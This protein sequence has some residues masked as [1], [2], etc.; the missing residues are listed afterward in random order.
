MTE[1]VTTVEGLRVAL[2]RR[3]HGGSVGLVPTM[4]AL[5]AGHAA[6]IRRARAEMETVVVSV[7]VNPTQ[8]GPA[9]D[10]AT[11]PRD[12]PGDCAEAE[13]NGADLVFAPS[14]AEVYPAPDSVRVAVGGLARRL[15]GAARPGHFD[16]VATVVTKLFG[17][18][19]CDVAYFGEKDYQQLRL[20]VQLVRELFLPVEIRAVPIVREPDGLALSSR[21]R[22]LSPAA[23]C[24]APGLYRALCV[25]RAEVEGGERDPTRVASAIAASLPRTTEEVPVEVDYAVCVDPETLETPPEVTG[26]VRLLVAARVGGI[27]LIDNLAASPPEAA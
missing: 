26:P 12:L 8:F 18:V 22:R 2:R 1:V 10:F 6:L 27:R 19:G 15:E 4:G 16:G 5:H 23:R 20:V 25:G 13:A 9:E 11:Y 17:A 7:F 21:N 14:V 3:R 24:V